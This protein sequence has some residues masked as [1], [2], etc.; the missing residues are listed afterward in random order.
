[1]K[2]VESVTIAASTGTAGNFGVV[3]Y[4]PLAPLFGTRNDLLLDQSM[5]FTCGGFMPEILD[6]ACL[7][8]MV[9][10]SVGTM[11]PVGAVLYFN[12]D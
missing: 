9:S 8:M 10:S 1:V 5:F 7:F 3:L 2:S 11:G 4:K 12:E 6:D